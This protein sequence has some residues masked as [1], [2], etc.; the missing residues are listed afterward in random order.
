MYVF[1]AFLPPANEDWG[2]V[3]FLH[4]SVTVSKGSLYDVSSCL[5]AWSH[6]PSGGL[7][8]WSHVSSRGLCPRSL[9]MGALSGES[10]SRR[11][12][13]PGGLCQGDLLYGEECSSSSN[14]N[15]QKN[16]KI[17]IRAPKK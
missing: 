17:G 12:L 2:K 16:R 14:R 7:Y 13:C 6:V 9:S 8:L 10:L 5:A 11:G 15:G 3:M 1:H 4:M